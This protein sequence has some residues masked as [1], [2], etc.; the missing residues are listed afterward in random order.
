M[1]DA[2]RERKP[3]Q[4][5][6]RQ[7][8]SGRLTRFYLV[9]VSWAAVLGS[10]K[11]GARLPVPADLGEQAANDGG[12]GGLNGQGIQVAD[13]SGG[14]AGTFQRTLPRVAIVTFVVRPPLGWRKME[15]DRPGGGRPLQPCVR[16]MI[17]A[18]AEPQPIVAPEP[19][20]T[21]PQQA[22]IEGE[23]PDEEGVRSGREPLGQAAA[24]GMGG[25]GLQRQAG[26]RPPGSVEHGM[27]QT[28]RLLLRR[29]AGGG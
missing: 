3:A 10:A 23:L 2:W 11:S 6:P 13:G 1:I 27:H 24:L 7:V 19:F 15:G 22:G 4:I 28:S 21:H 18:M 26:L 29:P 25:Q 16:P 14:E 5:L 8:T 20:G 17:A 12:S 9:L